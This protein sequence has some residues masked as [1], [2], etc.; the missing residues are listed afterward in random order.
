[1]VNIVKR[2]TE[3]E[4][5]VD[6]SDYSDFKGLRFKIIKDLLP[7]Q[8]REFVTE[9]PTCIE[10]STGAIKVTARAPTIILGG[11][12]KITI[13]GYAPLLVDGSTG[14]V[15][16]YLRETTAIKGVTDFVN[17]VATPDL[18][19]IAEGVMCFQGSYHWVDSVHFDAPHGNRGKILFKGG[20]SRL[21][22]KYELNGELYPPESKIQGIVCGIKALLE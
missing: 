1:M 22:F 13:D 15:D 4:R 10:Q 9:E 11:T 6:R 12:G 5:I 14:G 21:N 8:Y 20:A 2:Q 17:I 19:L 18:E 16:A 3:L 7:G